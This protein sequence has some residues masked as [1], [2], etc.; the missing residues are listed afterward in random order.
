M[1]TCKTMLQKIKKDIEKL[2]PG[3]L[4]ELRRYINEIAG[5]SV[6]Y[7]RRGL[8]WYAGFRLGKRIYTTYIGKTFREIDPL[9]VIRKRQTRA[10]AGQK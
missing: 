2:N 1:L 8:Y 5:P 4:Q 3:E 7:Y 9:E 10:K 6:S